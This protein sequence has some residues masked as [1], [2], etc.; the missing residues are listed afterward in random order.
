MSQPN[1]PHCDCIGTADE[2]SFCRASYQDDLND[3]SV[4]DNVKSASGNLQLS[5]FEKRRVDL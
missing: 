4:R 1:I 3:W 5:D 2:D